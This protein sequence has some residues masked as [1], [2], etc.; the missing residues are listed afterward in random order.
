MNPGELMWEGKTEAV[1]AWLD[2]KCPKEYDL[3]AAMVAAVRVDPSNRDGAG[4]HVGTIRKAAKEIAFFSAWKVSMETNIIA[5]EAAERATA[6]IT[7]LDEVAKAFRANTKNDI[8]SMKAASE[9]VQSEVA[10]MSDKYK[11]AMTLLNS[12][13]FATAV[14]QAERMAKALEC[15]S[16]LAETKVSVGV[17]SGGQL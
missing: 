8:T 6:A 4:F 1:G 13:E 15:I 3:Q 10:Q 7:R 9:R 16:G 2:K 14:E 5:T 11:A 17:F 12:P